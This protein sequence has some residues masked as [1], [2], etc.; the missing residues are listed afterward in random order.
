MLAY[1]RANDS[2]ISQGQVYLQF[3]PSGQPVQLTHDPR[4][5]LSPQFSPDSSQISYSVVQPWETWEVPILGGEPHLLLPNSSSLSWIEGGKKFLFSE[6]KE[7]LHMAVVTTDESRGNSRD[8]YVPKGERSMAHHSY[9]SPDGQWVLIVEMD[10]RGDLESC[11]VVSFQHSDQARVVGPP[12]RP[13]ISGAWSPDGKWMYL[14]VATDGFHIWRQRFAGGE[15]E[16]ITF[17]PTTQEGIAM[18]ADGKSLITS[19]GSRDYTVWLHDKNGDQQFSTESATWSPSFSADGSRLYFF[20]RGNSDGGSLFVK[21]LAS[22]KVDNVLPGY[23]IDAYSISRDGKRVVFAREDSSGHSN[24]WIATT[25]HRSS[26]VHIPSAVTEDSPAFLPGGDIM[27]R[28]IEGNFSFLYRMKPDGTDRHKITPDRVLDPLSVSTDGRWFVASTSNPDPEYPA[29]T[30]AFA[31]DG[32]GSVQLCLPYCSFTWDTTGKFVYVSH[33]TVHEGSYILPV[34][35]ETGLPKLPLKGFVNAADIA[36]ARPIAIVDW[37]ISSAVGS[38]LQAYT[39]KNTR[40]NL[41]R[42]PLP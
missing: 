24:L 14:N 27:F 26:P 1:I 11:R 13:C 4:M 8:V 29:V 9:L 23:D 32:S 3:L 36:A 19:V 2:L 15:P 41:Y 31:V 5:K 16:Q 28:A 6:I 35:P 18:A 7:G 42:I 33:P 38:S 30:K 37:E 40:R 20:M 17:G 25:D 34:S 10:N 21:D 12:N 22:G 39:K